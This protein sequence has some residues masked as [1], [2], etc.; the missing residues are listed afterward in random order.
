M[1]ARPLIDDRSRDV[2]VL[3]RKSTPASSSGSE[4]QAR[5]T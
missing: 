2:V 5:A 1:A 3:V 4:G